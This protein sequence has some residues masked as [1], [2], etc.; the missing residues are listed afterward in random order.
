MPI[1][2][3]RFRNI[4]SREA[5]AQQTRPFQLSVTAKLPGSFFPDFFLKNPWERK[6]VENWIGKT[7]RKLDL[8]G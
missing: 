7:G 6:L 1:E 3:E 8:G 5:E 4:Q 2:A